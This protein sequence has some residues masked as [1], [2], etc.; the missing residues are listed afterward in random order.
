MAG[1]HVNAGELNKR[2][3]IIRIDQVKMPE[4]YYVPQETL[5]LGCWAKVTRASGTELVKAN[6]GFQDEKIRFLIRK[7]VTPVTDE[8]VVR[9]CGQDYEIEYVN[10]YDG[11]KYVELWGKK[12][13]MEMKQ[14][15]TLYI[16]G[17]N[18]AEPHMT[19]LRGVFVD[20]TQ[21]SGTSTNGLVNQDTVMLYIPLAV[22]AENA[23]T[24]ELQHY[25][26]PK[27][28]QGKE[29]KSKFWTV[30]PGA[31]PVGCFFVCGE[32]TEH[33]KYQVIN[34]KYD[35]VYR[36]Q[37]AAI[38]NFGSTAATYLEVGGR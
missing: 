37:S 24:G 5:I 35:D 22:T 27:Q 19:V 13:H 29:D 11:R 30:D 36:I 33:E 7:S 2:I 4:G 23:L 31:G 17:D 21:A 34:Q 14:T 25:L 18:P 9:F 10:P 6:A 32:V 28:Y 20:R 38:N 8:M 12:L 26:K 16:P 15:V 3:Q 1:M